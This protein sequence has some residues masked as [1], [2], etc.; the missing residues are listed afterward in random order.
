MKKNRI[1]GGGDQGE[2][3]SDHEALLIKG[4]GVDPAGDNKAISPLYFGPE[5]GKTWP[6]SKQAY[7]KVV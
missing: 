7:T 2:R 3:V 6:A 4:G 1:E 5:G